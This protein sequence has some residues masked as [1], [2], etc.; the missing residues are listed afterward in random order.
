LGQRCSGEFSWAQLSREFSQKVSPTG[1][2]T[3]EQR[4]FTE[5]T[6]TCPVGSCLFSQPT[7]WFGLSASQR[8]LAN[9]CGLAIENLSAGSI[10]KSWE[11][12]D[13]S[14]SLPLP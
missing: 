3:P 13:A 6:V 9:G 2:F 14:S 11:R 4:S 5:F 1:K 10:S 7:C 8:A 12:S